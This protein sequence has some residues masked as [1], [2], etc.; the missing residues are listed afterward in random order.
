MLAGRIRVGGQYLTDAEYQLDV[1][2][3][4]PTGEVS[5]LAKAVR[6]EE[7]SDERG[8]AG[9]LLGLRILKMTEDDSAL[10]VGYLRTCAP[11]ERRRRERERGRQG[12]L[13]LAASG[14][15]IIPRE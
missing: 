5:L 3:E 1:R 10:Y 12:V 2:L 13:E 14:V 11:L 15:E 6:F 9:Y 8:G 7:T 4:L